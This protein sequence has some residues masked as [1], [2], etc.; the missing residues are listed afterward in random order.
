MRKRPSRR[1]F[2]R[3]VGIAAAGAAA[4][5]VKNPIGPDPEPDPDPN[6]AI[7]R[8][9]GTL[10][11]LLDNVPIPGAEVI[12]RDSSG[13]YSEFTGSEGQYS[14]DVET[15]LYTPSFEK[16]GYRLREPSNL[17]LRG[18]SDGEQV[19]LDESVYSVAIADF[20]D[21][22]VR[23]DFNHDGVSDGDMV[24]PVKNYRWVQQPDWFIN[25]ANPNVTDEMVDA[26]KYIIASKLPIFTNGFVNSP[27]I[28]DDGTTPPDYGTEGVVK[29]EWEDNVS[30]NPAI[31]GVNA[32]GWY[33]DGT[34]RK[35][36]VKLK[37]LD[38]SHPSMQMTYLQELSQIM[39]PFNDAEDYEDTIF[40]DDVPSR[41][42]ITDYTQRDLDVG[43][44]L[45]SRGPGNEYQDKNPN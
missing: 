34:I 44:I 6:P 21:E 9:S 43:K 7:V 27:N 4:G 35:G 12:L 17:D 40:R 10:T 1:N 23:G 14:L 29:V 37:T 19:S 39:G 24:T 3:T 25:R 16:E 8:V 45:Y 42:Y 13:A 31:L 22:V 5:C 36:Y 26:A 15:G 18:M 11:D 28:I 2:L 20:F 33:H 32:P 38:S 30:G 41:P